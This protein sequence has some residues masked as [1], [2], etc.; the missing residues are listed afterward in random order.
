MVYPLGASENEPK[1]CPEIAV[2][3]VSKRGDQGLTQDSQPENVGATV[4]TLLHPFETT[5]SVKPSRDQA[6]RMS[7]FAPFAKALRNNCVG[8]RASKFAPF[9]R[10]P[11]G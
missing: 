6:K 7:R 1:G 4:C 5:S 9:S 10:Q 11:F 2:T 3:K 8:S